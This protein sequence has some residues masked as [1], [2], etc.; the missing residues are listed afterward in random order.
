MRAASA[1]RRADQQHRFACHPTASHVI[2]GDGLRAGRIVVHFLDPAHAVEGVEALGRLPLRKQRRRR[3][4]S[5]V[6]LPQDLGQAERLDAA[7]LRQQ[8]HGRPA[9]DAA[10][11][12]RVA[13][14]HQLEVQPLGQAEQPVS[15]LVPEHRAFIDDDAAPFGRRLHLLIDEEP[16]QGIGLEA[17]FLQHFRRLGRRRQVGGRLPGQPQPVVELAEHRGFA[18]PGRALH[19]VDAVLRFE[20]A[21]DGIPLPVVELAPLQPGGQA[22]RADR[23]LP[24]AAKPTT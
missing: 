24:A 11:L 15:V 13:D 22:D 18:G 17:V 3:Q 7:V 20:Q 2:G 6:F 10:V 5:G 1:V 21:G 8:P 9:S 4:V 12:H 16:G 23:A 14:Q 19:Q